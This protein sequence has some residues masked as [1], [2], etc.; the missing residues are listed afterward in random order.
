LALSAAIV[1]LIYIRLT[2]VAVVII[3]PI[4]PKVVV[5]VVA[6]TREPLAKP[7]PIVLRV[8]LMAMVLPVA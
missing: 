1:C 6:E 4:L 5:A 3:L 8:V 7:L 2:V